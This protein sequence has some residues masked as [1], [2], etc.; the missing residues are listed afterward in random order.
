MPAKYSVDWSRSAPKRKCVRFAVLCK[1]E[2]QEQNIGS[3]PIYKK[4]D[5]RTSMLVTAQN[6]RGALNEIIH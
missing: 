1:H 5:A 4:K 2:H 3:D 6:S